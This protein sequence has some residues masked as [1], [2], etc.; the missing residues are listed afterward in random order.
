M[1]SSIW[2][3]VILRE[4]LIL[5]FNVGHGFEK[6]QDWIKGHPEQFSEDDPSEYSTFKLNR[7]K[8]MLIIY[9]NLDWASWDSEHPTWRVKCN[10]LTTECLEIKIS[11]TLLEL[12]QWVAE[13]FGRT[14][15]FNVGASKRKID[16]IPP[17]SPPKL[18]RSRENMK[19]NSLQ[20]RK[21]KE[22]EKLG[23]LEGGNTI[24]GDK[25]PLAMGSDAMGIER[26]GDRKV[27]GKDLE[28]DNGMEKRWGIVDTGMHS[29]GEM[30]TNIGSGKGR[31]KGKGKAIY[32]DDGI[33]QD[34]D[35]KKVK[36]VYIKRRIVEDVG[37]MAERVSVNTGMC[38]V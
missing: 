9:N 27:K 35:N 31:A 25:G 36:K 38:Q 15:E 22:K 34:K 19:P 14:Y 1:A 24:D 32:S 29:G 28:S 7:F 11:S 3:P 37:T 10:E 4:W 2:V 18:K 33:Q 16:H 12:Y 17:T 21:G 30:E 8:L 20:S 26:L 13:D 5:E 6:A 23:D